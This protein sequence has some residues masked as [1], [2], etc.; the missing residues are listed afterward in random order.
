MQSM[1]SSEAVTTLFNEALDALNSSKIQ[2]M[3]KS[4]AL[5]LC[6]VSIMLR[7]EI[8][9]EVRT[10][11]TN[12]THVRYNPTFFLKL[13]KEERVGLIAHE[14]WHVAFMHM[15]RLGDRDH[16]IWNYAGD[17][18]INGLLIKNG[19]KLP[20]NGLY[21]EKYDGWSTDQVY[22][23]LINDEDFDPP[24]GFVMDLESPVGEPESVQVIEEQVTSVVMRAVQR[25]Q[26]EHGNLPDEIARA[27]NELINPKLDWK[28]LLY[29][30]VD[31]RTKED[32]TWARPNRKYLPQ[33]YLP[34]RYSHR[35]NNLTVAIDTSGSM[36]DDLLQEILTE[37]Q[38]INETLQPENLIVLDCDAK[39]H[40]VFHVTH[41]DSILDFQFT[42]GGGTSCSPILQYIEDN[43][44][45][46]L[47]YFTDGCMNL[48]VPAPNC[49]F[50]WVINGDNKN[51]KQPFGE[52]IYVNN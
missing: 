30:F 9:N 46:L 33:F 49:P 51:F 52:V 32:Y 13:T 48:S 41:N 8:S 20:A 11:A 37:L 35:I 28:S 50:L 15:F 10:A 23:D 18:V 27:I 2:L 6:S 3:T 17:F 43:P 40:N 5:F 42:G 39:I 22:E 31:D 12:G 4:G 25:V 24:P 36:T 16:L 47:I 26:M 29:R 38:Y 14:V 44:T 34:S 45:N 19:F 21:N 1:S 7:H